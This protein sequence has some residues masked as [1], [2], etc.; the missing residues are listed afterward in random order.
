MDYRSS[1]LNKLQQQAANANANAATPVQVAVE[2]TPAASTEVLSP[3]MVVQIEPQPAPTPVVAEV[4]KATPVVAKPQPQPQ[5]KETASY[6]KPETGKKKVPKNVD[7]KDLVKVLNISIVGM[8]Q[9]ADYVQIDENY[10]VSSMT[11]STQS[12]RRNVV[13]MDNT[14]SKEIIEILEQGQVAFVN[15]TAKNDIHVVTQVIGSAN[16]QGLEG[17]S[18][19]TF[20]QITQWILNQMQQ[21]NIEMTTDNMKAAMDR[22]IVVNT[23]NGLVVLNKNTAYTAITASTTT[24]A[25]SAAKVA[26]G[27]VTEGANATATAATTE[28]VA[29]NGV[30]TTATTTGK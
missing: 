15:I 16:I 22:L 25:V 27:S 13:C 11:A 28:G 7:I 21:H 20:N 19:S 2:E 29:T 12:G 17:K 26:T 5:P 6:K 14:I 1:L 10:I 9:Q 18:F 23:G 24:P 3:E 30:A 8:V 4:P